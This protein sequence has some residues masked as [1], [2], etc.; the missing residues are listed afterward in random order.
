MR[1]ISRHWPKSAPYGDRQSMCDYCGVQWRRSQL[2]RDASGLLACPDDQR[3]RD[4]VTLNQGNADYAA[5]QRQ[6]GRTLHDGSNWNPPPPADGAP[7]TPP[8]APSV[9]PKNGGPTGPLSVLVNMWLRADALLLD[10]SGNVQSWVD[11]SSRNHDLPQPNTGLRPPVVTASHGRPAVV[12]GGPW[13]QTAVFGSAPSWIWMILKQD[14]WSIGATLWSNGFGL[15]QNTGSPGLRAQRNVV[16]T[17]NNGGPLGTWCRIAQNNTIGGTDSLQVG[18]T[19]V[20]D[21]GVGQR[22]SGTFTLGAGFNGAAPAGYSLSELLWTV[23]PPTAP[24][25]AALDAYA[26]AYYPGLAF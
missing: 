24:E 2:A 6:F 10:S 11:Q 9:A 4:V 8:N 19:V 16:G 22:T 23:G 21:A 13:L 25:I 5:R 1:T 14:T 15:T 12:F 20:T 26:A 3:G 17:A 18:A 7:F